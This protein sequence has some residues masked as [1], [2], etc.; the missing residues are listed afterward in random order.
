MTAPSND[1]WQPTLIGNNA[2]RAT[3]KVYEEDTSVEVEKSTWPIEASAVW[4]RIE[5][6]PDPDFEIDETV[7][8]AITYQP[9][10]TTTFEYLLV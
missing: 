6:V 10:L 7:N 2:S 9:E 3:I 8:L 5:V 4:Y 1:E